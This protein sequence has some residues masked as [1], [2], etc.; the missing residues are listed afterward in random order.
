M[1]KF[2]YYKAVHEWT[3]AA[4]KAATFEVDVPNTPGDLDGFSLSISPQGSGLLFK[5]SYRSNRDSLALYLTEQQA[6]MLGHGLE[7]V[8]C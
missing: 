1:S 7:T 5:F 8:L 4:A 6:R 2:D 3:T